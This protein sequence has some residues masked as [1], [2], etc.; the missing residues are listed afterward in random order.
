[1]RKFLA[2]AAFLLALAAFAAPSLSGPPE[3]WFVACAAGK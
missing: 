2:S 1:M 3:C